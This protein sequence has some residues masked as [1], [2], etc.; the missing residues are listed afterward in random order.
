MVVHH[1]QDVVDKQTDEQ[2]DK[3][4]GENKCVDGKILDTTLAHH[5]KTGQEKGERDEDLS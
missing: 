1:F 5:N 2:T 3:P 4:G